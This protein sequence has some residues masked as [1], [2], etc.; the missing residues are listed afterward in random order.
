L[1]L[2]GLRALQHR[3][4]GHDRADIAQEDPMPTQPRPQLG[5]RA[6]RPLGPIVGLALIALL[7]LPTGAFAAGYDTP[8]L[9]SARHMGMG[10][11]AIGYV[12]DPSALFHNP[13]GLSQIKGGAAMLNLSPL[14]GQLHGSPAAE[15]INVDSESA[16]IPMFLAGGAYTLGDRITLGVAAF[17]VG[18]GSGGYSYS[19][20]KGGKTTNVENTTS[21]AFIE[22]TPG[23]SVRI[24]D[25]LRVGAGWRANIVSFQ[26]KVI[27]TEVG[28]EAVP[29]IDM[30]MSGKD[31]KGFRVGAQASFADLDVG[32]VYRNAIRPEVS[33]AKATVTG[34]PAED[35]T[36]GFILPS[37]LGL[38]LHYR[39]VQSWRFG[40]DLEYAFNS[41]NTETD[42]KGT[43]FGQPVAVK[44]IA[45]WKDSY[46]LRVGAARQLLAG[47]EARLGYV[48]DSQAA[49][50]KYPSA[51]GTPPGFTQV[52]TAGAGWDVTES[53]SLGF[54][55]AYR[56]GKGSVSE[57]D[58]PRTAS[59]SPEC[60]FCGQHGDYEITIMGAYLDAVFRF[61]G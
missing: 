40:L 23:L 42:V 31:F 34:V 15:A 35:G 10:G 27:N 56:N 32:L 36:F 18:G 2:G 45:R 14:R 33:A 43:A 16:L 53:L 4:T 20:E 13:A 17:P 54:A 48:F 61:G 1:R 22:V 29:Y 11:V 6:C 24:F 9:Y 30:D 19:Y 37:K 59:G 50:T 57:A 47:V 60:A 41:E 38:G 39:G 12:N 28:G 5:A 26:R 58:I 49:N 55:L 46:T 21:L 44:N 52:F 51:F 7:A 8:M 25:W 3:Q